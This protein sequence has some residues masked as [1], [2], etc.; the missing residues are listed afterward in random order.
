[1]IISRLKSRL[2]V[3][4]RVHIMNQSRRTVPFVF[5]SELELLQKQSILLW[6]VCH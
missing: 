2:L 3:F 1:M 4:E 5:V 6:Q